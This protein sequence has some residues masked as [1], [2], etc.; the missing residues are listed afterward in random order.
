ME[1]RH[2]HFYI[3]FYNT[4]ACQQVETWEQIPNQV[5]QVLCYMDYET[6]VTPF[7]VQFMAEG[8][9]RDAAIIKFG[10]TEWQAR[11]IGEKYGIFP[12]KK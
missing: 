10:I 2:E 12:R 6:I 8:N 4:F 9:S 11:S 1:R 7:V 3:L 5:Q